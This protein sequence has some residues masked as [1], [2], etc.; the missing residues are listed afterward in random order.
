M[1]EKTCVCIA[2]VVCD[3][4]GKIIPAQT[5]DNVLF[6]F[7]FPLNGGN[8]FGM[9]EVSTILTIL[10]PVSGCNFSLDAL[11]NDICKIKSN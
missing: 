7:T 4:Q 1:L 5:L 10:Y 9:Y 11:C 2:Y 3:V 8:T 6:A